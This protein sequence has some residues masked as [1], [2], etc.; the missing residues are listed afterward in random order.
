MDVYNSNYSNVIISL[1]SVPSETG[2]KESLY[3][4][5]GTGHSDGSVTFA[6]DGRKY[7]V[8]W[9][10]PSRVPARINGDIGTGW[11]GGGVVCNC[12]S[13]G[14]GCSVGFTGTQYYCT[15]NGCSGCCDLGFL[16]VTY[17]AGVVI[18]ANSI[19]LNGITYQ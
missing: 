5:D 4:I 2:D 9:F 16:A 1:A 10:D 13:G 6:N 14:G 11:D 12:D 3:I 18:A 17:G 8:V 15:A 19:T 7:W